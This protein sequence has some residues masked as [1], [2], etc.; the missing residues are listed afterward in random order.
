[1]TSIR[2]V[3]LAL[4]IA[5]GLFAG[6]TAL[7]VY[8]EDADLLPALLAL[9]PT[10]PPPQPVGSVAEADPQPISYPAPAAGV[11]WLTEPEA[12]RSPLP[13]LIVITDPL[14]CAPCKHADKLRQDPLVIAAYAQ[15]DSIIHYR[16]AKT[17][18]PE[19]RA[20]WEAFLD[21]YAIEGYPAEIML[22]PDRNPEGALVYNGIADSDGRLLTA[23]QY[24]S[25]LESARRYITEPRAKAKP[26]S[27][28]RMGYYP[29][30]NGSVW[31]HNGHLP[32]WTHLTGGEH[33][34]K[35]SVAWLKSLDQDE[36]TSLHGDDHDHEVRWEYVVKP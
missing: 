9:G 27:T 23:A 34:G 8:A 19:V 29:R 7:C 10:T 30:R 6:C 3:Y 28:A 2:R 36:I 22:P 13:D 20:N 1:M 26:K 18:P 4:A 32:H 11:A 14:N 24:A 25:R 21:S 12:R 33:A 31:R 16:P 5:F 15:W 35:F 17:A